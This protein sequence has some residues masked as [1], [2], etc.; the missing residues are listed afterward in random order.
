MVYSAR[1]P[2]TCSRWS[3]KFSVAFYFSGF[4]CCCTI[5]QFSPAFLSPVASGVFESFRRVSLKIR[6]RL[7]R[8]SVL[9]GFLNS[10]WTQLQIEPLIWTY[11]QSEILIS[12]QPAIKRL[13]ALQ[14]HLYRRHSTRDRGGCRVVRWRCRFGCR[15]MPFAWIVAILSTISLAIHYAGYY[16]TCITKLRPLGGFSKSLSSL[17]GFSHWVC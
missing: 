2:I 10:I 8:E 9:G 11:F 17:S 5:V 13:T 15:S 7:F 6:V 16:S 12:K 1:S 14:P 4:W 3:T